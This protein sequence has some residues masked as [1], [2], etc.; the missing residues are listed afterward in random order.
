MDSSSD[1][2]VNGEK[3]QVTRDA[4]FCPGLPVF[5]LL[6]PGRHKQSLLYKFSLERFYLRPVIMTTKLGAGG[7]IILPF[8]FDFMHKAFGHVYVCVPHGHLV[9]AEAR[10]G[11]QIPWD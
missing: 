8:S 3:W 9:S 5:L 7:Q 1:G 6:L 2:T 11:R 4:I 10:R